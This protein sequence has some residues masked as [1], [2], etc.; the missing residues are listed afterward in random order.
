MME[1]ARPPLSPGF[2]LDELLGELPSRDRIDPVSA[3]WQ[4][5]QTLYGGAQLCAPDRFQKISDQALRMLR[6][7]DPEG[8][9]LGPEAH[10]FVEKKLSIQP[11]EDYRVD[12]EDG[13]GARSDDE[14][15]RCAVAAAKALAVAERL[16]PRVG[17]RIRSLSSSATARRGLRTLALFFE[18]WSERGSQ[19]RVTL[20]KVE[21]P[22]EVRVLRKA[23]EQLGVVQNVGIELMV[24]SPAALPQIASWLEEAQGLCTAIHFGPNDFLA[25]CGLIGADLHHPLCSAARTKLLFGLAARS[26]AVTWADGPTTLLPIPPHRSER[27]EPALLTAN[28][29][30]VQAAWTKHRHDVRRSWQ[31]GYA[32]SWDLHPAQLVSHYAEVYHIFMLALPGFLARLKNFLASSQQPVATASEFDD[33]A[34]A[35][36]LRNFF[37]RALALELIE[38][39]PDLEGFLLS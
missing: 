34:T 3:A 37:R 9:C 39:T 32:Q 31:E 5:V 15:D 16:P 18:H 22:C 23:L 25:S 30:A 2:P 10:R 12:F 14:E 36:V 33:A 29:L 28:R 24:E 26:E 35:R 7:Y 27:L 17:I 6:E 1:R 4:P 13:F 8:E 38:P 20:P 11:I 21:N 19:F